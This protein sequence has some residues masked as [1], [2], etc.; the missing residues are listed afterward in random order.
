MRFKIL[1]CFALLL[2]VVLFSYGTAQ[3]Q[4]VDAVKDAAKKTAEVTVDAA[5]KTAEVTSDVAGKTKDVTVDAAKKTADVT[6]N[7]YDK[8]DNAVGDVN[9][10]EKT[11][12][13]ASDVWNAT[14]KGTKKAVY[15]TGD[16]A[17]D[18]GKLGYDAG[19]ETVVTT[20]DG[21]KWVSNKVWVFTKKAADKTVDVVN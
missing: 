13:V 19:K 10:S 9:I 8:A 11:G 17:A 21:T 3:A 4:V 18:F 16:K 15:Y 14:V 2:A 1:N 7:T 5:K 6:T 20:W 12:N